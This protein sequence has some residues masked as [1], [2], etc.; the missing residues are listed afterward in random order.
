MPDRQRIEI[1]IVLLAVPVLAMF[2]IYGRMLDRSRWVVSACATSA[3]FL[4]LLRRE[5]LVL[6]HWTGFYVSYASV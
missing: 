1:L 4:N 2:A 6:D 3:I 5:T